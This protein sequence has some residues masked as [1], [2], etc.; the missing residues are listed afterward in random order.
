M[1]LSDLQVRQAC[2]R[3]RDWKIFDS[4]GLDLLVR[5]NGSKLWRMKYR[6]YGKEKKLSFGRYPEV[7]LKEARLLRDEARVEIGRGGDPARSRVSP[8]DTDR[9]R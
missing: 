5:S 9:P 7:G 4:G 1:A 8:V 2:P 3:E 6:Y